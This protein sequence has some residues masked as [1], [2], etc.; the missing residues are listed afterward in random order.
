[1]KAECRLLYG[2]AG[3]PWV[4]MRACGRSAGG[5]PKGHLG[6][7]NR[8]LVHLLWQGSPQKPNRYRAAF[9]LARTTKP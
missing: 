2:L 6:Q 9:F 7:P 3:P 5:D 8:V 4:L 1:M